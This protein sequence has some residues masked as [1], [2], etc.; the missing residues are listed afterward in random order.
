[1]RLIS[2][3]NHIYPLLLDRFR[4]SRMIQMSDVKLMMMKDEESKLRRAVIIRNF[5]IKLILWMMRYITPPSAL[6]EPLDD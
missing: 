1:M 6:F 5:R 2:F 3:V 4:T